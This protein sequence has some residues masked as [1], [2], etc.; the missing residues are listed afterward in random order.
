M[1]S[2][3]RHD[4]A[5]SRIRSR[6]LISIECRHLSGSVYS[7]RFAPW[8]SCS[9][10]SRTSTSRPGSAG[11]APGADAAAGPALLRDRLRLAR[12]RDRWSTSS[13]SASTC[14]WAGCSSCRR[15]GIDGFTSV[16]DWWRDPVVFYK[17]VLWTMLFEVLGL[18]L[19]LRPAQPAVH[20]AAGLVP[21]LAAA[22]ARSG[23]HRGRAGCRSPAA[24]RGPPSTS[25]LY[26]ALL[27]SRS[28]SR[29]S[30]RCRAG[31]SPSS[32]GLL[33]AD[34]A[35][36]QGDLPG[37]PLRGLRHA[38][39]HLPV[40]Q[41]RPGRG[42]PAGDGRD[43]VGRRDVQAQPALPVRGRRDDEQQPGVA[44]RKRQAPLPPGLPRRPAARPASRRRWP[45]AARSWSSACRCCS[46]SATGDRS[47]TVGRGRDGPVPPQHHLQ[48]ARWASR[49]SG[50]CS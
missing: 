22:R 21:L 48:P 9:R 32:L 50:T 19:R 6:A 37:R 30:A 34:R 3:R 16:S 11:H 5:A 25:L 39:G 38:G 15:P 17:F 27:S 35:A 18:G 33:A 14:S 12:R 28:W 46:C 49:W 36:R 13:R 45:T 43:L 10:T 42:R 29:R 44:V 23:C 41:R 26:A 47:P 31:R 2:L 4:S 40:R 24:T 20:A 7:P 8:A 1:P